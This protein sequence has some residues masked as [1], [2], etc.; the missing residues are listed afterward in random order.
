VFVTFGAIATAVAV[1]VGNTLGKNELDQAKDNAKKLIATAVMVAV[2]AGF[3]LFILS[4]F[5]LNIYDVSDATKKIA[6]FNI[7]INALF[8]PVFSFNVT[9]YFTLRAGGDTKSTFLMD[10]GYMWI[11]PVPTALLL[12]YLTALPVTLMFLLVQMLDIPKMVIGLSRYRKEHWVRNLAKED[13]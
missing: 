2:A 1:L 9:L 6:Q 10:A 8:I 12:S 4:F 11:L 7:R 13:V 3:I 5:I